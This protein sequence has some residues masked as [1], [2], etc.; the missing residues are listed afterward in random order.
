MNRTTDLEHGIVSADTTD[1]RSGTVKTNRQ[2]ELFGV[3]DAS[4][5]E[6]D[7][8]SNTIEIYDALPKYVWKQADY[9][10]MRSLTRECK[11]RGQTISMRMQP[12]IV[13]RNGKEVQLYPGAREELVEDALRRL[14]V[15]GNGVF[16]GGGAGVAFTLYEL[17]KE[18]SRMGHTFSLNEIK[19]AIEVSTATHIKCSTHDGK[20][21][22]NS[23]LFGFSTLSTRED[24]AQN[25]RGA[26][27]YVQF[28]PLVTESIL[29]M[30]YRQ[31]NYQLGMEIRSSLARF[32]FKRLAQYWLQADETSPY[33]FGL[34]SF[35]S[36]SPKEISPLMK[37]NLKAMRRALDVLV[38][39]EVLSRYDENKVMEG[40]QKVIDAKYDIWAHPNFVKDVIKSNKR[41]KNQLELLEL[42]HEKTIT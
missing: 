14:A 17:R 38:K 27:C 33:T 1:S 8:Y 10:D 22:V 41:A 9:S 36:Q 2:M 42:K 31:Y 34:M 18:L 35:L 23:T 5:R 6:E 30:T 15:G 39:H 3:L 25:G 37:N 28:N 24:L 26:K 32:F 20:G 16:I 19:E 40:K 11:I 4:R 12:A 13:E 21:V 29:N 7:R